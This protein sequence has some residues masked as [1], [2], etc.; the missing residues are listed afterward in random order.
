M[1][2]RSRWIR[3]KVYRIIDGD[4][5]DMIIRCRIDSYHAPELNTKEGKIAYKQLH[6]QLPRGGKWLFRYSGADVYY[7]LL[8]YFKDVENLPS[9][10][11][12]NTEPHTRL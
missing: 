8:I 12:G 2:T 3:G 4:T 9:E 5:V 10:L 6:T 1:G 11:P 7:R